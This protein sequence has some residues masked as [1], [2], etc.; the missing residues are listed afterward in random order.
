[1]S[2]WTQEQ[3]EDISKRLQ[4]NGVNRPCPRCGHT[5]FSLIDGYAVFGMVDRLDD[6]GVQNLIPSVCVACSRCGFLTFHALGP[7]GLLP[8]QPPQPPQDQQTVE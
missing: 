4:D 7:L 2:E 8:K 3:R 1:M 5:Q 6:D